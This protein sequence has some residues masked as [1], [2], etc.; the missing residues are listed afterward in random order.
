MKFGIFLSDASF[1][2]KTKISVIGIKETITGKITQV[3]YKN[4]KN[5]TDAEIFGIK[6]AM[7]FASTEGFDNVVFIC[8]NKNAINAKKK[9]FFSKEELRSQFW[10]CQFL[11]LPREFMS[12]VDILSKEVSK[13]IENKLLGYKEKNTIDRFNSFEEKHRTK[14][15]NEINVDSSV[16]NDSLLKR[17]EQFVRIKEGS[18]KSKLFQD[19]QVL[20]PEE[21][22]DLLLEEIELIEKDIENIKDPFVKALGKTIVD[23]LIAY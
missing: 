9:D 3:I 6:E 16:K 19:I 18:F 5:P 2:H 17:V 11:W 8:D 1:D 21:M 22:S 10:Y 7:K 13:E 4:P 23:M 14:H 15:I 12:E 20:T